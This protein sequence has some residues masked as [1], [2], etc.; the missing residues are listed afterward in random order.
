MVLNCKIS[1]RHYVFDIVCQNFL[2]LTFIAHSLKK[3]LLEAQ[4]DTFEKAFNFFVLNKYAIYYQ[5]G[6]SAKIFQ[7]MFYEPFIVQKYM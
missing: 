3:I 7:Q 1:N 2:N 4:K 5:L 6:L